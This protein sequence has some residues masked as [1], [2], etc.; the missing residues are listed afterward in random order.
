MTRTHVRSDTVVAAGALWAQA[1]GRAVGAILAAEGVRV[2][3]LKGPEMQARIFGTPAAYASSDLDLLVRPR[4]R[5]RAHEVLTRAG[6]TFDHTNSIM[7]WLS[8][9][10]MYERGGFYVD[11]HWGVKG[12]HLPA[13]L[14]RDLEQQLW[15]GAKRGP[16]GMYEPR[17]E[18]LLVFL[19]IH[20]A[21]HHFARPEWR[22]GVQATARLGPDWSEVRR[23]AAGSRARAAVSAA[24][25]AERPA[26]Q[27]VLDGWVGGAA[28]SVSTAMRG[29]F[30]PERYRRRA[31]EIRGL[32]RMGFLPPRRNGVN[33]RVA[34]QRFHVW[35]GVCPPGTWSEQIID[36]W[37]DTVSEVRAPTIVE[38][39][40]GSGALSISAARRV[41]SATVLATDISW[42]ACRN[43]RANA[44][45][46]RASVEVF[47]GDLLQPLPPSFRHGVD[48]IAA[49]LPTVPSSALDKLS[50]APHAPPESFIG[51]G[52][53]GLDAVRRLVE[54]AP[55]WL[56]PHGRLVLSMRDWQWESLA[57]AATSAGFELRELRRPTPT[58]ALVILER[59]APS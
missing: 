18:P 1:Q 6:F 11:L 58:G 48:A 41:A 13:F 33:I 49:H 36:A 9:Q 53:D 30:V 28:W 32:W 2:L 12:A 55:R 59:R 23:I 29:H 4:D 7:W 3:V 34:G 51:Q 21:G 43:A 26:P 57:P 54:Q 45:G 22:A 40:T 52:R 46:C 50:E 44:R 10:A 47:E 27:N 56:R 37:V 20:A 38:V 42:V 35:G 17:L 25:D 19:A 31:R 8:G 24:L 5:R 14:F 16:S 39:G 15:L